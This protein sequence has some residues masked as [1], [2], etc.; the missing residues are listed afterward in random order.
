[1]GLRLIRNR[2]IVERLEVAGLGMPLFPDFG[3]TVSRADVDDARG[4]ARKD[5][6]LCRQAYRDGY[7]SG[8]ALSW[9]IER[10]RAI[11]VLQALDRLV[12]ETRDKVHRDRDAVQDRVQEIATLIAA[13]LVANE[14]GAEMVSE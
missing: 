8:Y 1:M 2:G 7:A 12:G 3:K 10:R 13:S 4:A 14:T 6:D 5:G 11:P 9:A